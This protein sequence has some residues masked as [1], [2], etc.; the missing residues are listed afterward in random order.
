MLSMTVKSEQNPNKVSLYYKAY[1]KS[2]H[3]FV[4]PSYLVVVG[5][6]SF[7]SSVSTVSCTRDTPKNP[8]K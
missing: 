7:C 1:H 8:K 6:S 3:S 4:C 5:A 2:D